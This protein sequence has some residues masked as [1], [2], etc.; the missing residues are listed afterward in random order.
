MSSCSISDEETKSTIKRIYQEYNYLLDPHG[1]VGYL[2]LE[3]YLKNHPNQKGIF[4]ETAHP[5]KFY[6]VIEP[7]LNTTLEMPASI[8]SV[9]NKTSISKKIKPEY[10]NLRSS[11]YDLY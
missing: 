6:N 2:A 9:I 5:I 7:V 8:Q 1:A 10:K 4:L 3:N 11:I